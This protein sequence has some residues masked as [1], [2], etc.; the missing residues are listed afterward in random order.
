MPYSYRF[1]RRIIVKK[2]FTILEMLIA[3]VLLVVGSVVTLNMFSL[4]MMADNNIGHSTIALALAQG[5]MEL[6]KNADSWDA[7][8][9]FASPRTNLGGDYSDFDQEVIVNGNPK[10]VQVIVYWNALGGLQN[11]ELDTLLT[12]YNY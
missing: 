8:D 7:V 5:E 4:G 11:L 10:D 9:S 1:L 6:I 2:G 12:N 3:V